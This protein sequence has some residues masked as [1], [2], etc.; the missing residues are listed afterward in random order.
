MRFLR[1]IG[2]G[3]VGAGLLLGTACSTGGIGRGVLAADKTAVVTITP[4]EGVAKARPDRPVTVKVADGTLGEVRV[5]GDG[6]E[7]PGTFDPARSTWTAKGMLALNTKYV[8]SVTARSTTGKAAT[9]TSSFSTLKP[10][11]TFKVVDVTPGIKGETVGVGMPIIV[12]LSAAVT[13]RKAVEKA[14]RVTSEKPSTGAW[15]WVSPTQLIYRTEKYWAAHQTV[16]LRAGLTGVN[17]GKGVYGSADT[18]R[19]FK[20]GAAQ[21]ATVSVPG[22]TMK[23][24]RDG[25]T[26]RSAI[27]VSSGNGSTREYTT[28]S[29]VHLVMGHEDPATM[30][31]PG[32]KP[33]DPGYYKTIA[34]SAVRFSSSGEYTH[35]APW[36]V[37]SQGRANVSHGCVNMSPADARWFY[38][39]A[40]RGDVV[41]VTGTDRKIEWNNGW[42][43][44]QVPFSQWAQ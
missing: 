36:S 35:S 7:I 9:A 5:T 17:G 29:G 15:R 3:S 14:L 24:T 40:R 34:Q 31:S 18:T 26:L 8:V 11:S 25:R 22:H 16:R 28:T 12:T 38:D 4:A 10:R 32:K 19:S 43:Y 1:V 44:W 33:G 13:D 37:G 41:K 39:L 6:R 30:I 27:P 2:L 21:I 20:V 42:G 23:V